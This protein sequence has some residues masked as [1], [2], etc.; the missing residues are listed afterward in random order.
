M[1]YLEITGTLIGL[2]YLW[3]EYKASIYLW[4]T[5]VIMPA[6]YIFVYYDAGLYADTGINIYYLLAALYGWVMWR[7]GNGKAEELPVTQTPIRL[8]LPLSLVLIAAF[9][10]I[11]WLLINYTDSN[12]PW[13]D[14]F[15]TALSIVGMWMLAKK[16]VEQWLVW[17]VVDAVSYGLYVYKDLYFTSGLY[18][19]YAVIAVFGYFKWKRMMP[20]TA[21]SPPSRKEGVGVIGINYP[22]LPLDYRP[23]AV[24]L[25]NGEYPVHELPL[26]LLRQAA[27]IVC[28]DG[29][30]NEYVRRGFIPDAIVG[31][32]DSI[33]EETKIHFA[34]I[35]HKDADQETNDQT[36][37]VEF[38]IAQGKKHIL[39]V[40][41][42]GKREDHTL[43]N[44]SL[45]MEYAKKVRVQ[46]VTNYGMF[47]PACGDAMF[48]SL[49]GGQVSIFNF[50][51][52]QMRADSLEYP[53]REFTNWWQGTLNKALKD[54][55]AIYANGEYLV[56]RAYR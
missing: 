28:C 16:Y 41:A 39:I 52:T 38:C 12:V 34:N 29:A 53:L 19:F 40:G 14:S 35:L 25:A 42:T 51:S 1:N 26:S 5:G 33:S 20:H 23:E 8:L 55:F 10:L 48:D 30:A 4:A 45:L 56:Y 13:T 36:K 54:K 44:I 32:G 7:R 31:D 17:M 43:G 6:I 11:A 21:D 24:I 2:L 50:G 22:L 27:Y 15:I 18:G 9:F 37:A 47:T 46:L 3:L 49:P